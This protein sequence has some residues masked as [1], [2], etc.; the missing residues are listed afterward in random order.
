MLCLH[1]QFQF[2]K[3]QGGGLEEA[4]AGVGAHFAIEAHDE[5]QQRRLCGGD[6]FYCSVEPAPGK[7]SPDA[8]PIS[9]AV[10]DK[11]DGIYAVEYTVL[12]SGEYDGE[13]PLISL[14]LNHLAQTTDQHPCLLLLHL[15]SL[16][17]L[18]WNDW[19]WFCFL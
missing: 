4:V 1:K 2:S 7:S 8:A 5:N 14:F 6:A 19:I 15:F 3:C 10:T 9:A 17:S 12:K 18:S 16:S 13:S 11:G